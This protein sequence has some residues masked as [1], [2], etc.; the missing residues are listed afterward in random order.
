VLF[1]EVGDD[2]SAYVNLNSLLHSKSI[3]GH[4]RENAERNIANT[5]LPGFAFE[6]NQHAAWFL[7]K[8][9]PW[10][11]M[12]FQG[13]IPP[14]KFRDEWARK[15][16]VPNRRHYISE[17]A[18]ALQRH[19]NYTIEQIRT[20]NKI[21]ARGDKVEIANASKFMVLLRGLRALPPGPVKGSRDRMAMNSWHK[22]IVE[23]FEE[24]DLPKEA[25]SISR[26][27]RNAKGYRKKRLQSCSHGT[28]QIKNVTFFG[29]IENPNVK[30][31]DKWQDLTHQYFEHWQWVP[32]DDLEVPTTAKMSFRKPLRPKYWKRC[33]NKKKVVFR[34]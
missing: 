11:Q 27:A 31:H 34:E 9:Y 29:D 8:H 15:I 12:T 7:N 4:L 10:Q 20:F 2:I 33:W 16:F 24:F 28:W 25:T 13:E 6:D 19:D 30:D 3:I 26:L 23:C 32:A 17:I 18:A 5:F 22:R 1:N 21:K 14:E